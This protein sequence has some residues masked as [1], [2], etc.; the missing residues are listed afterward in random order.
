MKY[1]ELRTPSY[2]VQ[3]GALIR[4]LEILKRVR[5]EAGVKILLAEKAF[6]M[7]RVYPLIARY[8]DGVEFYNANPRHDSRDALAVHYA[9]EFGLIGTAGSDCHRTEDIARAGIGIECLPSDSMEMMHLLRSRNFRLLKNG[10]VF[11]P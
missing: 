7:F 5:E 10:E 6:S 1:T 3:E 4:N 9:K 11:E 8:L 2:I